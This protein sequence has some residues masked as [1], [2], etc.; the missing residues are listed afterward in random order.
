MSN[1]H[2]IFFLGLLDLCEFSTK[3]GFAVVNHLIKV[4]G[5]IASGYDVGCK[6][7]KQVKSHPVLSK[8]AADNNYVSLVGAFHGLGHGRMCQ[9]ENLT[10]YVKGVGAETLEGCETYFSKSNAL[11]S[12]TRHATRFHRQQAIVNYMKHTDA[13]DTFHGLCELVGWRCISFR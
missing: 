2:R 1:A 6:F 9:T 7:A 3:Y 13:F 8:L 12:T 5:E 4:L 10:T 11:A